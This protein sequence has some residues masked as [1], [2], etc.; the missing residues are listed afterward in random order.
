MK[1]LILIMVVLLQSNFSFS[2]ENNLVVFFRDAITDSIPIYSSETSTD[3]IAKIKEDP[4][5]ENW[6]DVEILKV[7]DNRYKVHIM[8]LNVANVVPID[9]WVDKEQCGVWLRAWHQE[10]ELF[11]VRL[12]S[13]P[14]KPFP[15]LKLFDKMPDDFGKYTNEEAA[16][17]LDYKY[18][19]GDYWI[20]T[21]IIK[22]KHKVIG[23]TRDFCPN[24]YDSCN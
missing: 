7:S 15:F 23:W 19:K 3:Y 10:G 22:D 4:E 24:V 12:Y 5:K 20:K 2:Q 8:P 11:I 16:P 1:K 9:G 13:E 17:V 14:G 6:H 21:A 18:Y